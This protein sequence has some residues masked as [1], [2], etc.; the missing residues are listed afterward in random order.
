MWDR[1]GYGKEVDVWAAGCIMGEIIDGNPIFPG[2]SEMDQL[3]VI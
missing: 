1:L 3:F 2:E